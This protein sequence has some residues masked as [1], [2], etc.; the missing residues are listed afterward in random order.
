MPTSRNG[1]RRSD[2]PTAAAHPAA[3][4]AALC[5]LLQALRV[6]PQAMRLTPEEADALLSHLRQGRHE[7]V[8]RALPV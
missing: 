5:G 3:V 2:A 6:D 8:S 7:R 4:E 1:D